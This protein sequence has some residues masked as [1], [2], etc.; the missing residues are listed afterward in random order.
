MLFK[1]SQFLLNRLNFNNGLVV[2][3]RF[4]FGHFAKT[5]FKHHLIVGSQHGYHQKRLILR[6]LNISHINQYQFLLQCSIY[7]GHTKYVKLVSQGPPLMLRNAVFILRKS[8]LTV[9]YLLL[10]LCTISYRVKFGLI[11]CRRRYF[12][13][14]FCEWKVW[15][16]DQNFTEVYS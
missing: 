7:W 15:Y 8:P 16:F 6:I 13:M 2:H 4:L 12:Q 3:S 9:L 14:H 10:L 11:N 1:F 5:Y